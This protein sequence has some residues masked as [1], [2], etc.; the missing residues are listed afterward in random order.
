V[1]KRQLKVALVNEKVSI[2]TDETSDVGHREQ[3]SV[4]IIYFDK[5]KNRPIE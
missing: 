1:I 2:M 3:L 5:F 4:V